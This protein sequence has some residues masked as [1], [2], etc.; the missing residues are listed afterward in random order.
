MFLAAVI[1]AAVGASA[2]SGGAA[3]PPDG[4][5]NYSITQSGSPI[6]TSTV[7]LKRSAGSITIHESETL[8]AVSSVVDET[9]D[10]GTLD[11]KTYLATYTKGGGSQTAH[12]SF[13]RAGATITLDGVPGNTSFNLPAGIRNAYVLESAI[14]T[15]FLMLPAQ[16]HSSRASQFL[17]VVP[18][19][20]AQLTGRVSQTTA[21][22][23]PADLPSGDVSLAIGGRISFDE[24]YDP[25]TYV[26]H[27]VSVPLQDVLIKLTK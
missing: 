24:W 11:P 27:A 23:R 7:T 14:M 15:G 3:A 16:I 19:D 25:N 8:G 17:Q 26:L 18:S 2:S 4:T 9:L 12:V 13:D 22:P 20:V 5:Y 1:A 10:A 21:G 6:G